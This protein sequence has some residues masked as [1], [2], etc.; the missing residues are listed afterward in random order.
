VITP[1]TFL[2]LKGVSTYDLSF[3]LRCSRTSSSCEK[4]LSRP[5]AA[6]AQMV[7]SLFLQLQQ[8]V[9]PWPSGSDPPPLE[10]RSAWPPF[11]FS[12]SRN[13]LRSRSVDF[14]FTMKSFGAQFVSA[15]L[16]L[17]ILL[18]RRHPA[19]R[20]RVRPRGTF[21]MALDHFPP[22]GLLGPPCVPP[23]FQKALVLCPCLGRFPGGPPPQDV[24]APSSCVALFFL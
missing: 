7:C 2:C 11:F 3:P 16:I 10:A 13:V 22:H 19:V 5:P 17:F 21:P 8:H 14:F 15:S 1:P 24:Q 4:G 9:P 12:P 20:R 18:I 6:F 23:F